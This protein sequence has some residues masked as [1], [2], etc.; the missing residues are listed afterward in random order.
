ME[1]FDIWS[2]LLSNR[3]LFGTK[4]TEK[5]TILIF[6]RH[7]HIV[8][9]MDETFTKVWFSDNF[10]NVLFSDDEMNAMTDSVIG[11]NGTPDIKTNFNY[12]KK[13]SNQIIYK[14]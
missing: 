9:I 2:F 1:L 12:S 3:H 4:H 13:E 5:Q 7:G 14:I 10:T 8:N 6:F 11:N